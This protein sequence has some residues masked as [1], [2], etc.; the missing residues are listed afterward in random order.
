[1]PVK[2]SQT[3]RGIANRRFDVALRQGTDDTMVPSG[4][5][6]SMDCVMKLRR[7]GRR[8]EHHEEQQQDRS[9]APERLTAE[10]CDCSHDAH[11]LLLISE[12]VKRNRGQRQ[13]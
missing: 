1:M 2:R 13:T 8:H 4:I 9:D 3:K 11:I 12:A 6:I 10:T 7:G 5:G